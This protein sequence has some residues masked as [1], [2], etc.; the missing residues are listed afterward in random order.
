MKITRCTSWPVSIFIAGD[1][2]KA[3]E[4]CAAYCDEVG[5]CITVTPTDYVYRGG[6][7]AGVI[8]GLINYPRFPAEHSAITDT[9]VELAKFLRT[10]LGQESFSI[11]TPDETA[12]YSWRPAA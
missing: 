10:G 3:K 7:D 9:A 2:E 8:V 5:L 11:Q 12:F 6:Q 1:I 4:I